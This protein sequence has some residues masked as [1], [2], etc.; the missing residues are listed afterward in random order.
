[1]KNKKIIDFY[2]ILCEEIKSLRHKLKEASLEKIATGDKTNFEKIQEELVEAD[3]VLKFIDDL[4]GRFTDPQKGNYE[5]TPEGFI[6]RM[7]DLNK[8]KHLLTLSY[9]QK[10]TKE[11]NMINIT[12][13]N[14]GVPSLEVCRRELEKVLGFEVENVV[15]LNWVE[16]GEDYK[17]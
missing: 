9:I 11:R 4:H 1:M 15:L 17:L 6:N 12:V 10:N 2:N 14:N 8:V 5:P 7:F 16:V 3:K 13:K